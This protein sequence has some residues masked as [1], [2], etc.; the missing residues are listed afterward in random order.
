MSRETN[1]IYRAEMAE[2]LGNIMIKIDHESQKISGGPKCAKWALSKE[3]FQEHLFEEF[4][5]LINDSDNMVKIKAM[6][7]ASKLTNLPNF[8]IESYIEEG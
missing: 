7:A 2:G 6:E 8:S 5:D 4:M 3:S 1:F